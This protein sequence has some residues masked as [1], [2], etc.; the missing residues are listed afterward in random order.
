[1][2][3]RRAG[4]LRERRFGDRAFAIDDDPEQFVDTALGELAHLAELV[5]GGCAIRGVRTRARREDEA[6]LGE[7]VQHAADERFFVAVEPL[8]DLL[9]RD[10]FLL[11]DVVVDGFP[12]RATALGRAL[13]ESLHLSDVGAEGHAEHVGADLATDAL[14]FELFREVEKHLIGDVR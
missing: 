14:S 3:R 6:A 8:D 2:Q 1:M 11:R 7:V 9:S 4:E 12:Q 10:D 13:A 5:L